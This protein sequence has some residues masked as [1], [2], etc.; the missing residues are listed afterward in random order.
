[1]LLPAI[2]DGLDRDA[3]LQRPVAVVLRAAF[4][5]ACRLGVL[6]S[7]RTVRQEREGAQTLRSLLDW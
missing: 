5:G 4:L 1:M 3:A 7:E 6:L 2:L